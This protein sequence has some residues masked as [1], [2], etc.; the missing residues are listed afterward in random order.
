MYDDIRVPYQAGMQLGG[1]IINNQLVPDAPVN[2]V[3][4]SLNRHGL[5]AGATGQKTC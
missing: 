4:K 3:L 1:I 5:I 2:L